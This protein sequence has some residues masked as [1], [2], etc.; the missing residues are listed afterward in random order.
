MRFAAVQFDIV[1]EDKPANHAIVE[2]MVNAAD[3]PLSTGSFV[4]LPELGDT[5]FSMNLDRI[6]DERSL[7]WARQLAKERGVFVQHGFARREA[8]SG[9]PGR[10]CAAII[11]PD[12][13][14]LGEYQKVH[15]FSYGKE[16]QHYSGGDHLTIQN[17]LVPGPVLPDPN[18]G[19]A[20]DERWHAVDVV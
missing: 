7:E 1:W 13:T 9:P 2:G 8:A 15:P 16:A 20:R 6:V 19:P 18:I 12:G 14:V 5:G 4:L 3:P 17:G 10:N 11:S